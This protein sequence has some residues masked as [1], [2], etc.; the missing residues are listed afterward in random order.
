MRT[1]ACSIDPGEV[2]SAVWAGLQPQ[3][4]GTQFVETIRRSPA[5][6]A[7]GCGCPAAAKNSSAVTRQQ[8]HR[9]AGTT[10]RRSQGPACRDWA[11][12][13]ARHPL[14]DRQRRRRG[15]KPRVAFASLNAVCG[16][17]ERRISPH[18]RFSGDKT[19]RQ[20]SPGF[21]ECLLRGS[22]PIRM[23]YLMI[24]TRQCF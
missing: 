7:R 22:N 1:I 13:L 12:Y 18:E 9:H 20:A 6:V 16:S 14:I 5:P 11:P 10:T 21:H 2:R 24:P 4:P 3:A 8:H 23:I 17:S 19:Q 15:S